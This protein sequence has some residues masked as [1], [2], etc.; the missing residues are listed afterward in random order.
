MASDGLRYR[1]SKTR[2]NALE[3]QLILARRALMP[4]AHVDRGPRCLY[5]GLASH[6]HGFACRQSGK[7]IHMLGKD[8]MRTAAEVL[9]DQLVVENVADHQPQPR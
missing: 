5:K 9:V 8:N 4:R 6:G 2:V 7:L 3:A 1:A